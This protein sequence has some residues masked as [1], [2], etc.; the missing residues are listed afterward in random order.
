MLPRPEGYQPTEGAACRLSGPLKLGS[1]PITCP[2]NILSLTK[3]E[4]S[5]KHFVFAPWHLD[6]KKHE[7]PLKEVVQ[8][9]PI[10]SPKLGG[11]G[12]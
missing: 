4:T 6:K 1:S 11:F 5:S 8:L 10:K 9:N 7:R 2:I 3:Y 12:E